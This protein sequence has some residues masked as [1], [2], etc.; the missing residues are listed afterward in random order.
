MIDKPPNLRSL[1]QWKF[2]MSPK[3]EVKYLM[4]S[5]KTS[6]TIDQL[7]KKQQELESEEQYIEADEVVQQINALMVSNT[8]SKAQDLRS[9][10]TADLQ[11]LGAKFSEEKSEFHRSNAEELG[12]IKANHEKQLQELQEGQKKRFSC[13][14]AHL[15]ATVNLI[16]KPSGHLLNL[17]ECKEKAVRT[18]QYIEADSLKRTIAEL[19]V[20]E[21]NAHEADRQEKIRKTLSHLEQLFVKEKERLTTRHQEVIHEFEIK[22][23][24]DLE[25]LEK[26][27]FNLKNDLLNAQKIEIN[28]VYGRQTS[29]VGRP[30]SYSPSKSRMSTQRS[31]DSRKKA[32]IAKN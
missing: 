4:D 1:P 20:A 18:K 14:K 15:E 12:Q 26:K 27:F 5:P 30:T 23:K 21:E 22:V 2:C 28:I 7:R 24:A 10:H 25:K 9:K 17:V 13:E 29:G 6:L 3:R 11:A 31:A 16:F 19:R 8:H 32:F